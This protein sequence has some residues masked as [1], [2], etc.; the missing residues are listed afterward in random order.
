MTSL[1]RKPTPLDLSGLMRQSA[2]LECL[3]GLRMAI[4]GEPLSLMGMAS[5]L[6]AQ[7]HS[8]AVLE[9]D[10]KMCAMG[11]VVHW[12]EEEFAQL[13]FISADDPERDNL[14]AVIEA[15]LKDTGA[16]G[17]SRV[18]ADLPVSSPYLK[19]FQKNNFIVWASYKPY[20][21]SY[22]DSV[23]AKNS[24]WRTWTSQD[25]SA[26]KSIYQKLVASR[27]RT[28]EPMTRSKLLG[29]VLCD[30][31][32]NIVGYV[33]LDMGNK[34]VWA[35][36]FILSEACFPDVF[37]D[38]LQTLFVDYGKAVMVC[39]R[40]YQPGLRTALDA[41]NSMAGEERA[42]LVRH[43][44]IRT[45]SPETVEERLFDKGKAGSGAF[46]IKTQECNIYNPHQKTAFTSWG[47]GGCGE[48]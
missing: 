41:L 30:Q 44:A 4:H 43:L 23:Q 42:L 20:G 8:A 35:Q 31:E 13:Q 24:R 2:S 38:L 12:Q 39:A 6:F 28:Y 5:T 40:S 36:V 11:R 19:A 17:L 16:W 47:K 10:G 33:D 22:K 3:D 48:S 15:L 26:M 34:S 37:E 27:I 9:Q 18:M 29:K 14:S 45:T 7:N 46:S 1:V 21:F 32:G 25:F